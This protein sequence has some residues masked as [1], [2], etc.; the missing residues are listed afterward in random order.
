[1]MDSTLG[2][3]LSRRQ[4]KIVQRIGATVLL[5][6][7]LLFWWGFVYTFLLAGW[8]MVRGIDFR[9]QTGFAWF[10][11]VDLLLMV[12]ALLSVWPVQ[13]WLRTQIAHFLADEMDNPYGLMSELSQQLDVVETADSLHQTIA[14]WLADALNVPYVAV[15]TN[16]RERRVEFGETSTTDLIT[17]PLQYQNNELGELHIA[18]RLL[19]GVPVQVDRQLLRDLARQVSLT[20]HATQLSTDLQA[21]RRRIVTAREE[22][23]RQLRRDLHDGLGPSLA[24]MTMQADTARELIY[25]N[26]EMTEKLLLKLVE[27]TQETVQEV[28]RIVHGL[29]PPA[30][31]DM[32]LFGA[33]ELL[34]SGFAHPGMKTAVSLPTTEP[35]LSAALEVAIYRITQEALT[36]ISK[37]AEAGETAVTLKVHPLELSL[38]ICDNGVG[39]PQV[40]TGGLGLPS[41]RE[42]AEE[43]GGVLNFK[44]N[45]PT[46]CCVMAQFPRDDGG[47]DG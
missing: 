10:G 38:S 16:Q 1:M 18:P 12:I 6:L 2:Q 42:R 29:R 39:L 46:G 3:L 9:Q 35:K 41:M 5:L 28:R 15:E 27:Q 21:S 4:W 44:S 40:P 37:H 24:T 7:L 8:G 26:P 14:N 13:R 34:I 23:R 36:N 25:D 17:I 43:L 33:L 20:L 32:G 45:N 30:L 31:D 19:G 47:D 11:W 22:G